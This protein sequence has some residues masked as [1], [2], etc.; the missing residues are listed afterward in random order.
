MI[1][2]LM[3]GV[4]ARLTFDDDADPAIRNPVYDAVGGRVYALEA[5]ASSTLPLILYSVDEPSTQR[6]FGGRVRSTATLTVTTY[7]KAEAG[8]L[9][10]S[11]IADKVFDWLDQC[12]LTVA[13]Y[14]RGY[15]RNVSI[16]S[17]IPEGEYL[18]T[19]STFEIVA[20]ATG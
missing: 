17:P 18:R 13:G 5:P 19:D 3:T 8:S 2:A 4:Y 10:A 11:Q 12:T 16:G 1:D 7:C 14:D 6:F 9:V 20:T 15:V